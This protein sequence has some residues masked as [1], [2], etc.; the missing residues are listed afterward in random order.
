MLAAMLLSQISQRTWVNFA[1]TLPCHGIFFF[2]FSDPFCFKFV[3]FAF[4]HY[5]FKIIWLMVS[6]TPG[7]PYSSH[8]PDQH[9]SKH[10]NHIMWV[11]LD[12]TDKNRTIHS[13][14]QGCESS[15]FNLISDFFCSSQNPIFR[16]S[17]H[18]ECNEKHILFRHF[19]L[20]QTFSPKCSHTPDSTT[21]SFSSLTWSAWY[22][23]WQF[24][25]T[26][27]KIVH[28]WWSLSCPAVLLG[29]SSGISCIKMEQKKNLAQGYQR[30][31]V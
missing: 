26:V 17:M 20:F 29:M 9:A 25:S 14:L 12:S 21:S 10:W 5:T 27:P 2:L 24:W 4:L 7:S 31:Y 28:T 11:L 8:F 30:G 18:F 15:D 6:F 3:F 22:R 23:L 19:R 1:L 13:T 16:L